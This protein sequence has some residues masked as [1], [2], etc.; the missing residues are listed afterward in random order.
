MIIVVAW[1]GARAPV[2]LGWTQLGSV[3]GGYVAHRA[4]L[5]VTEAEGRWTVEHPHYVILGEIRCP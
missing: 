4:F 3:G 1:F 2:P 5:T